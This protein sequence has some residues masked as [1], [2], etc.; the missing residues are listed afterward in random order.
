MPVTSMCL[1]KFQFHKGTIK[2][3]LVRDQ[4]DGYL[5]FQFHKGT[6]KTKFGRQINS[7][8]YKIS[9]P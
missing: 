8:Y 2:T 5:I 1:L 6:I 7:F 4:V 3:I 9:I